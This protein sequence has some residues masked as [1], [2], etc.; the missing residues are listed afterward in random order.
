MA[1]WAAN[2]AN[3][4]GNGVGGGDNVGVS[5]GGSVM[6]NG[7]AGRFPESVTGDGEGAVGSDETDSDGDP[8]AE[9]TFVMSR[10]SS[11]LGHASGA[12]SIPMGIGG[13][14]RSGSG[15]MGDAMMMMVGSY[16]ASTEMGDG[17][18]DLDMVVS[19]F[20]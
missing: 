10:P 17:G 1:N 5:G 2:N 13:R 11:G 9:A 16:G 20:C 4:T 3:G 6:A 15:I 7:G 18:M 8:V 19:I 12:M 14:S